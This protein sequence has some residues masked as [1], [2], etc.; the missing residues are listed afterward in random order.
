[1][2]R[3]ARHACEMLIERLQGSMGITLS[4]DYVRHYHK[5]MQRRTDKA[6]AEALLAS[7]RQRREVYGWDAIP[8]LYVPADEVLAAA[9]VKIV[10][11]E[12]NFLPTK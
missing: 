9:G 2:R 4:F 10:H 12:A 5:Q 8:L 1:M 7:A 6:D 11:S 3:S